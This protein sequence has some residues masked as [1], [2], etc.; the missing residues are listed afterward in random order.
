VYN[1]KLRALKEDVLSEKKSALENALGKHGYDIL[2]TDEKK[3]FNVETGSYGYASKGNKKTKKWPIILAILAMVGL[4]LVSFSGNS[5]AQFD[6]KHSID[7]I[8][9]QVAG[10]T[11][12]YK[13]YVQGY[14]NG[15]YYVYYD[16]KVTSKN[17][18]LKN[19][20]MKIKMVKNNQEIGTLTITLDNMNLDAGATKSYQVQFAKTPAELQ[21]QDNS[22]FIEMYQSNLSDYK[23]VV[24]ITSVN[25]DDGAYYYSR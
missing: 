3:A 5:K 19:M 11:E 14:T 23:Y 24:E 15:M 4:I 25:F 1:E 13:E 20:Q 12:E 21:Y 18:G 9:V 10:K 2:T 6:S 17:V 22:L 8:N 7:K 16:I